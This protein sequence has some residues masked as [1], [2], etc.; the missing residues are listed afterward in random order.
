MGVHWDIGG[1]IKNIKWSSSTINWNVKW[2][3]YLDE[4]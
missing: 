2:L 4:K 3:G 1:K